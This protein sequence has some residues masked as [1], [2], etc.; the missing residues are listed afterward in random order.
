MVELLATSSTK[1]VQREWRAHGLWNLQWFK[2]HLGQKRQLLKWLGPVFTRCF[3]AAVMTIIVI[4]LPYFNVFH[5]L[6]RLILSGVVES[7]LVVPRLQVGTFVRSGQECLWE[8]PVYEATVQE[9]I[10]YMQELEKKDPDCEE[11][12]AAQC[13]RSSG[14]VSEEDNVFDLSLYDSFRNSV[15]FFSCSQHQHTKFASCM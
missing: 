7:L 2:D 15:D 11:Q 3:A 12:N 5:A 1:D 4:S 13:P 14:K 6:S 9:Y 8:A 10:D